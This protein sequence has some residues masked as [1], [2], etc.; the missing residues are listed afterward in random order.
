MESTFFECQCSSSEHTLKFIYDE[1]D[2]ELY[3]SIY[4]ANIEIFLKEF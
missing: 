4:Y 1:E 3:T 2:R